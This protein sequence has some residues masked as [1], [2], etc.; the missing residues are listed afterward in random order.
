MATD[1]FKYEIFLGTEMKINISVATVGDLTMDDYE[2]F[3][4]FYCSAKRVVTLKKE[5]GIRMDSNNYVFCVDSNETGPGLLKCK[6]TAYIPDG[7]F[8]DGFRTEVKGVHTKINI[9]K[10]IE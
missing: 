9:I 2:F 10:Y 4:E 6:L 7:D 3:V 1:S 8:D 5:E